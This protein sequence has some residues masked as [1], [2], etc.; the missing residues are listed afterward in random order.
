MKTLYATPFSAEYWQLSCQELKKPK[1]LVF[2]ALMIAL[3]VAL[4]A[5]EIPVGPYLNITTGFFVNALGAMVFGPVVAI[6]AAAISDTLGC[7]L[8]PV[9]PYFFPFI[10]VEIASSLIFA[11]FLYRTKITTWRVLLS[12][13]FVMAICNLILNPALL[14]LYNK[15]VLGGEY[16]FLTLPRIV[17]NL[18]LFPAESFLLVL[19]LN[20]MLP[21]T[22]RM[23]LTFGNSGKMQFTKRHVAALIVLALVSAAAVAF[24]SYYRLN[25]K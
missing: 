10:F 17:K 13:F 18:C 23:G 9:G 16:A 6:L 4:K 25:L 19:F 5:I 20:V 8:F 22:G 24:Y 2:A 14:V 12:R 7:M 15:L 11:L 3:R 1:I 21:I